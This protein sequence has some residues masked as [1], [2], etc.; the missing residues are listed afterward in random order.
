MSALWYGRCFSTSGTSGLVEV[1]RILKKEQFIQI[2]M[3]CRKTLA[4]NHWTSQQDID[5][6]TNF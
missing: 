4:E 3:V 1:D 2:Q 5:N 6:N